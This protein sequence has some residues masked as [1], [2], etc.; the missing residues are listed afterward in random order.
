MYELQNYTLTN[1]LC[2]PSAEHKGW[3]GGLLP[4]SSVSFV[5]FITYKQLGGEDDALCH[6]KTLASASAPALAI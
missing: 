1:V 3:M 4:W 6:T 2:A 5:Q